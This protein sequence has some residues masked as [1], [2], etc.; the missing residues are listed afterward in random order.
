[1]RFGRCDDGDGSQM[2]AV[3]FSGAVRCSRLASTLRRKRIGRRPCRIRGRHFVRP[4]LVQ[5]RLTGSNRRRGRRAHAG[6]R[7][8]RC[9][10]RRLN[11]RWLL[12]ARDQFLDRAG[13]I[14]TVLASVAAVFGLRLAR[15]GCNFIRLVARCDDRWRRRD[16]RAPEHL[17]VAECAGRA[18]QRKAG[19]RYH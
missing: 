15:S 16:N 10:F 18:Q 7:V 12:F 19:R 6:R 14:C 9:P 8:A 1:M 11:R 13:G 4:R 3:R 5:H 17:A 2:R